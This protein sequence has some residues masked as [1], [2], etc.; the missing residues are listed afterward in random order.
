MHSLRDVFQF[1]KLPKMYS[2]FK[3]QI[4]APSKTELCVTIGA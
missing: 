2:Y 3:L 1:L 4:L